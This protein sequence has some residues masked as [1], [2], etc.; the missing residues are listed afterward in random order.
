MLTA[1][2]ESAI[3]EFVDAAMREVE[4]LEIGLSKLQHVQK[5]VVLLHYSPIAATN[6]GEPLEIYP[7]LGN[8]RLEEVID[9]FDV[10]LT[11]HGH[12]HYGSLHGKTGKGADVYNVALPVLKRF[13]PQRPYK[14]IELG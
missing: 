6:K 9:T 12:A 3:K 11:L 13:S 2:G 5:K 4:K 7:F 8:S 1:F 10:S 14:I